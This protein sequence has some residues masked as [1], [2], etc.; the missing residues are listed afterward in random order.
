MRRCCL[1]GTIWTPF[2]TANHTLELAEARLALGC[3]LFVVTA[4]RGA[5][6]CLLHFLDAAL[7]VRVAKSFIS[8]HALQRRIFK[9][10]S[11]EVHGKL[12]ARAALSNL[13]E[14]GML[15]QV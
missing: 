13:L 8:G 7:Q 11:E 14:Q 1:L 3:W 2:E 6:P 15:Y 4:C 10:A 9:K 5:L 12:R